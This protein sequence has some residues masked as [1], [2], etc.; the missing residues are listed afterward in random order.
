M[1]AL[2]VAQTDYIYLYEEKHRNDILKPG[3]GERRVVHYVSRGTGGSHRAEV[4]PMQQ[5]ATHEC[6]SC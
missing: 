1:P 5:G 2:E 6:L 4:A 3:I